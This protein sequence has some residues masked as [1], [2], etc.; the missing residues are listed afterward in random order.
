[1][2]FKPKQEVLM[3]KKIYRKLKKSWIVIFAVV[4]YVGHFNEEIQRVIVRTVN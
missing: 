3:L 1:M 4:S 2:S